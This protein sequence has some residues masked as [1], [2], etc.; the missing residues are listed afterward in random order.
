MLLRGLEYVTL[1][2]C[3]AYAFI[4]FPDENH[5]DLEVVGTHDR[6]CTYASYAVTKLSIPPILQG[7]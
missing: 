6:A 2:P 3:G 1:R 5:G 4:K 7:S